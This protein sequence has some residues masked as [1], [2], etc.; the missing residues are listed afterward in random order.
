[1]THV[2]RVERRF[3]SSFGVDLSLRRLFFV[4]L[5]AVI[6]DGLDEALLLIARRALGLVIVVIVQHEMF[7]LAGGSNGR[8]GG[9]GRSRSSS[10][11]SN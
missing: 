2:D 1:M 8:T 6:E 7:A 5:V 3:V 11:G 10:G 4:V 9:C